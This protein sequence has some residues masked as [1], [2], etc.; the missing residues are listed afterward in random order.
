MK[1]KNFI[2][3]I[4]KAF[5]RQDIRNDLTNTKEGLEKTVASY[6]LAAEIF[7][8]DTFKNR[9]I[10]DF[11]KVFKT[12]QKTPFKGNFVGVIYQVL[13]RLETNIPVIERYVEKCFNDEV[14]VEGMTF[15]RANI[16]QYV[17][18]ASFVVEYARTLLVHTLHEEGRGMYDEVSSLGS[19]L[20]PAEIKELDE[21]ARNFIQALN[22]IGLGK[23]DIEKKLDAIP[24][25]VADEESSDTV[26]MAAGLDKTDPFSFGFIATDMNP[27]YFIGMRVA[28]WQKGRYDTMVDEI[29]TINM[30]IL[31]LKE[32]QAGGQ[33][34]PAIER[35]IKYNQDRVA[36]LKLKTR[37]M[38]EENA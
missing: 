21:K 2:Q 15:L 18:A 17:S 32:L 7:K 26:Q 29:D 12:Y 20:K 11:Q 36:T 38:E 24:D 10:N 13:Q 19:P 25:V 6:K 16:I 8:S 33:T 22:A 23:Q 14:R 31:H 34:S 1:I 30:R 4:I 37:R 27:F 9:E 28:E 35:K 3:K 5:K